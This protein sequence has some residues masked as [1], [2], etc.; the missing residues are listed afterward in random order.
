MGKNINS[1]GAGKLIL[2]SSA[3]AALAEKLGSIPNTH[4]R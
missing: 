2:W 1:N 4:I 3:L